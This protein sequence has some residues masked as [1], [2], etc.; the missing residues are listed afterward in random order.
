MIVVMLPTNKKAP[1]YQYPLKTKLG[2]TDRD[3]KLS[4]DVFQHLYVISDEEPKEGDIGLLDWEGKLNPDD[5]RVG[6]VEKASPNFEI[7]NQYG[8]LSVPPK[9]G[10]FENNKRYKV[11]A[12]TDT[13][14]RW[15]DNNDIQIID[16]HHCKFPEL[17]ES[18]I[19]S[20]I[21]AYNE[22]NPI[23]E[24][25]V[26]TNKVNIIESEER[27]DDNIVVVNGEKV[28]TWT[29]EEPERL[30]LEANKYRNN[31]KLNPDNTINIRAK[32]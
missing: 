30:E 10:R 19:Q 20:Y 24:V 29:H 17:T 31:P 6:K 27:Y 8:N 18:F 15:N 28:F 25:L 12:T 5:M 2:L 23:K 14:L 7:R 32:N 21:K 22:G 26:E 13:S 1:I 11:V 9:D 16:Y 4:Q 3:F